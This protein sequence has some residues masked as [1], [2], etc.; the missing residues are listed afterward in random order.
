MDIEFERLSELNTPESAA[1]IV[2]LKKRYRVLDKK[3]ADLW[4]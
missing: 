3:I 1:L 2:K 4:E